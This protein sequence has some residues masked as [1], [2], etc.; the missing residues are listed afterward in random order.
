MNARELRAKDAEDLKKM[1]AD[2]RRGFANLR[3]RTASSEL[4]NC[5]QVGKTRRQIARILTLL[6][7]RE[8]AGKSGKKKG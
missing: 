7:E 6:R 2:E 8:L 1:L 5:A 3:F 4:E